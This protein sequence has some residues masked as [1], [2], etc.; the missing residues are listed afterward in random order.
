MSEW[1]DDIE[2]KSQPEG[3]LLNELSEKKAKLEKFRAIQ[4][5]ISSHNELIKKIELRLAEDP[6]I[7]C[8]EIEESLK[9]HVGL[10]NTVDKTIKVC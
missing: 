1:L 9:K 10:K 4:R 3:A 6:T 7:Q 5:D 2:Q 8:A